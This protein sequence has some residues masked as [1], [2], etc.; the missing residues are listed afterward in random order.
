MTSQIPWTQPLLGPAALSGSPAHAD[1]TLDEEQVA[2]LYHRYAPDIAAY[3]RRRT[4][5]EEAADL[6][7]ETFLVAWRRSADVP[8]EPHT[9]PWLYGVARHVLANQR[10]STKRRG[11]LRDRLAAQFVERTEPPADLGDAERADRVATAMRT[12]SDDDA[13]ILRLVAWEGMSPTE[14]AVVLGIEPNAARQR[15]HRA[16]VRLRKQLDAD[17]PASANDRR[18]GAS[19][20]VEVDA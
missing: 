13:E 19:R 3:A 7:S 5:P 20:A 4:G 10:R 6:V 17:G 1:A 8:S 11:R 9:L 14:I 15:L 16:R 18:R 2:Q 12:L